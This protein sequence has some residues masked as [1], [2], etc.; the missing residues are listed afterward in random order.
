MSFIL[1]ALKKT[2]NEKAARKNETVEI[3]SALLATDNRS[4]SSA[5]RMAIWMIISLVF[6][7]GG[8][9]IYFA[10]RQTSPPPIQPR[11]KDLRS[12]QTSQPI[13]SNQ[14]SLQGDKPGPADAGI[15]LSVSLPTERSLS[16][17]KVREK[18]TEAPPLNRPAARALPEQG[19]P[20]DASTNSLT[21]NGIA[22]QDDPAESIAVVNGVIV[23]TGMT[24]G[25]AQ[26]DRIFL[27]RVR[28]RG[29]SGTF[30]VHLAR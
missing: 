5:R 21:V 7:A 14:S 16:Q 12:V 8:G 28:F 2:E 4:Y 27:N 23:K 24:I 1:K 19:A 13:T 11:E 6:V 26:V 17:E 25:G 18:I 15:S 22:L 20:S 3:N 10:M 29:S 9:T 30:E